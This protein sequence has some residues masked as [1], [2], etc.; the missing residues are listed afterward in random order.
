MAK[1]CSDCTHFSVKD[2]KAPGY[3]K[4]KK[5]GKH[6]WANNEKCEKFEEAYTRKWY[7]REKLY[8]EAK[9]TQNK[10]SDSNIPLVL[11]IVLIIIAI[12]VNIFI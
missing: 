3:C 4:C 11:V 9:E 2:K 8:D 1:Y 10:S 5:V 7:D 6:V 12:I